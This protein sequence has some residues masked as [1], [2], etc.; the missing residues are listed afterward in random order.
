MGK[1]NGV[2]VCIKLSVRI[3][4]DLAISVLDIVLRESH[5]GPHGTCCVHCSSWVFLIWGLGKYTMTN[6]HH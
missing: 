6:T 4:C 5:L 3:F 1:K 2:C